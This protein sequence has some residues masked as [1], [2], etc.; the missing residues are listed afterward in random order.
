MDLKKMAL[1]YENA[2]GDTIDIGPR[3]I[4]RFGDCDL[5]DA[6]WDYELVNDTVSSV[7][8]SQRESTLTLYV[9]APTEAAGVAARNRLEEVLDSGVG[10]GA[11]GCLR[12]GGWYTRCLCV[13]QN[14]D[15]WWFD[16]RYFEV[17]C[18]LLRPDPVW[19]LE[20][21]R[22][23]TIDRGA[24]TE[25]LGKDH[26]FDYPHDYTAQRIVKEFT[27]AGRDASA[28]RITIYGPAKSPYVRIGGNRYK[29]DVDVP[30]G[31]LLIIDGRDK[32]VE[33]FDIDGNKTDA[34][35]A[36]QRGA[37]GSGD[38]IFERISPGYNNVTWDNSFGFE[39]RAYIE[40]SAPEWTI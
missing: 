24:Q 3:S 31:G 35:G 36:R 30:Q 13:A 15:A 27:L 29:V 33:L 25:T 17:E 22:D 10:N 2:A 34:Y 40:R 28:C 14:K 9:D 21:A 23:Y 7:K 39:I 12:S 38:Y 20:Q 8:R 5:F 37:R 4:Y 6:R 32:A 11:L 1:S 26:P 16:G 18:S 19:T